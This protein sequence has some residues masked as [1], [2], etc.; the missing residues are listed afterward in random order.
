MAAGAGQGLVYSVLA[1]IGYAGAMVG[2]RAG[3]E[4]DMTPAVCLSGVVACAVSSA[5]IGGLAITAG[6]LT[7]SLLLGTVQIGAQYILLTIA[8][9][10]ATAA[11]ITLT[12]ILEEILAPLW[13]WVLVGEAVPP[14]VLYGGLVII[15]ALVMSAVGPEA[16]VARREPL[17][18]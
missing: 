8:T 1:C 5:M 7:I 10:F 3:H 4:R 2:L 12:M 9:R 15:A 17:Q 6:D 16:G 18:P 14:M 11:D 13:V